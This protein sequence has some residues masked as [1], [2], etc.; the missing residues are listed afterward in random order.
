M[1]IE[2]LM[3]TFGIGHSHGVD[4]GCGKE[5]KENENEGHSQ[6][7]NHAGHS[8]GDG[9]GHSHGDGQS[10]AEDHQEEDRIRSGDSI[11]KENVTAKNV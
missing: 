4:D 7:H 6:S 11:P 1:V 5:I 9:D 2:L 3:H 8:H 10:H